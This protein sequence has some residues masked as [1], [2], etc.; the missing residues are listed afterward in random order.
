MSHQMQSKISLMLLTVMFSSSAVYGAD[1]VNLSTT[2]KGNQ[3]HPSVS[4]I[5]PWQQ[6]ADEGKLTMSFNTRTRLGDVFNH[7]ERAEHRRQ[8]DFLTDMK[9][10][11]QARKLPLNE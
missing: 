11:L 2:I 7:V 1:V 9:K 6:A 4:Y 5:V 10:Q 8:V 3:E